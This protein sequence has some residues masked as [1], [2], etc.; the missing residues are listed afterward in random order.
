MPTPR[1]T[2]RPVTQLAWLQSHHWNL[3]FGASG[4]PIELLS[5]ASGLALGSQL[6][7]RATPT[8]L[9]RGGTGYLG[10]CESFG[11]TYAV[12]GFLLE[13]LIADLSHSRCDGRAAAEIRNRLPRVVSFEAADCARP[14]RAFEGIEGPLWAC[15]ALRL[16]DDLGQLL[17]VYRSVD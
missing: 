15:R 7:L 14:G 6:E 17:L 13:I 10:G 8:G 9:M 16:L 4:L 2:P 11:G 3:D 12:D 1:L 5:E